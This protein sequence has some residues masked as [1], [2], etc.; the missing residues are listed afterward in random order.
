M[1]IKKYNLY[2]QDKVKGGTEYEVSLLPL[3]KYVSS[4]RKLLCGAWESAKVRVVMVTCC[5]S[6][7]AHT[8]NSKKMWRDFSRPCPFSGTHGLF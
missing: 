6:T 5:A 7:Q 1:T 4:T 3:Q 2:G 8:C